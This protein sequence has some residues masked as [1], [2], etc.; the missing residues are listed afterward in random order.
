MSN[1]DTFAQ[2]ARLVVLATLAKERDGTLNSRNLTRAVDSLGVPRSREWVET[3]LRMLEDLGA[4][5]TMTADLP[6]LGDVIIAKITRGGRDHVEGR[7]SIAGVSY[8][9]EA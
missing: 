9:A 5:T 1:Y 4:V 8:S 6:G 3:Q 7:A 2:D